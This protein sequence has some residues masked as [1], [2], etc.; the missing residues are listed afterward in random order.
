MITKYLSLLLTFLSSINLN[1]Q[2][3]TRNTGYPKSKLIEKLLWTDSAFRYPGTNSDMH[4]WTWG[5]DNNIYIVDDD[6]KNFGG[7]DYLAHVLK[8]SG[9]PPHHKAE[10]VTDFEAYDLR[11][12]IPGKL[13]RRYVSGI[14]AIDSVLYITIYD[15]DWNVEGHVFNYDSLA[16]RIRE[17]NPWHDLSPELSRH[18]GFI[19]QY[20]KLYGVAGIIVSKDYGRSWTNIPGPSDPPFLGPRFGG[21]AFLTF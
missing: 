12:L 3:I 19:D 18:M 6:G 16:K 2:T 20:S 17:Y 15:Y 8:I 1:S 4:W 14:I 13:L 5:K 11:A 10:T 21:M 9:I 7:P